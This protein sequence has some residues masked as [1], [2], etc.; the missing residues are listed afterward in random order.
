MEYLENNKYLGEIEIAEEILKK[1]NGRVVLPV[2]VAVSKDGKREDIPVAS[3]PTNYAISDIGKETI[4]L[5]SDIIGHADKVVIN[6]PA[7]I[8]ENAD[9]RIGTDAILVAATKA[10]FSVVGGGHSTE[11]VEQLGIADK[12]SHVSTGGGAA[13][14]FLAGKRMPAIEALKAAK[15][16]MTKMTKTA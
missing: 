10:K 2:D 4:K 14:D 1:F 12:I 11:A 9:F 7:G 15:A 5:F 8:F 6:G 13:I 16:R 3:L